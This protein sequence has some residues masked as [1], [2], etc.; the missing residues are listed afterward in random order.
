MTIAYPQMDFELPAGF[1]WAGIKASIKKN[2]KKDLGLLAAESPCAAAATFTQNKFCAAPVIVS[3]EALKAGHVRGVVSNAGCANAATGAEGL[4][5]ARDMAQSAA[6]ESGGGGDF[7]VC[8]TGVIGVQLPMAK[9]QKGIADAAAVL[10]PTREGFLDFAQS[11]LTTDTREKIASA[12]LTMGDKSAVIL[13]CAK[14]SGMIYPRMATLLSFAATDVVIDPALLQQIFSRVVERSLNCMTVDGDTSTNDTAIILANGASGLEIWAGS[15]S[16]RVFEEKLLE[17]MQSLAKQLARDG[18]GATK[19]IEV[20]VHGAGSFEGARAFALDVANSNLV[21]TAIYGRDANWGR[22]I[23]ALG[24]SNLAFAPA[25]VSVKLGPL[26]LFHKG[27]PLPL[28]EEAALKTLSQEFIRIE[29]DLGGA[30]GS[31]TAWTCDMTEKYIEIN[32]SYRS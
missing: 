2:G 20:V 13:G 3:R 21:K 32:A 30:E 4:N 22:I 8:S 7:L 26:E 28:D 1:S 6:T 11:I 14:G 17:V 12:R 25:N 24:N 27:T 15:Y 31:A 19:L 29:C 10:A 16:E 23:M 9:V 5:N 18:E